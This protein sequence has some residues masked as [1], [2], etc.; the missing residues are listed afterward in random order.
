MDAILENN[1]RHLEAKN[2]GRK[3]PTAP[4]KV[5]Y[6][7]S[8]LNKVQKKEAIAVFFENE[9]GAGSE[10]SRS[11]K[12]MAKLI[13]VVAERHQTGK[14]SEDAQRSNRV[15]TVYYIFLDDKAVRGSLEKALEVNSLADRN[16]VPPEV[17]KA[18]AGKLRERFLETHPGYTEPIRQLELPFE[19]LAR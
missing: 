4:L 19:P 1:L 17:R 12:T 6:G 10:T 2:A 9:A 5:Y 3:R 15:F 8:R 16:N 11:Y 7:W 13:D 14:E 18:I